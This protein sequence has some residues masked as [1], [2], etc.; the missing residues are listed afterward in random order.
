MF[1]MRRFLK[2]AFIWVGINIILT[3][4]LKAQQNLIIAN[5]ANI[6]DVKSS[7]TNP[8]ILPFQESQL[9]VGMKVFHVGFMEDSKLG[10]RNNYF[11][12]SSPYL[13]SD[14][15]VVGITGQ[16]FGVPIYKQSQFSFLI[17]RKLR[18]QFS[19]GMKYNALIH[20]Y[21]KTQ[22]DQIDSWD[23]VFSNRTM[24]V[25][26][27]FGLGLL[28][29][30]LSDLSVGFSWDHINKPDVSLNGDGIRQPFLFDFGIKYS[31]KLLST[32]VNMN[33]FQNSPTFVW[34]LESTF[35]DKGL[36]RVGYEMNAAKFEGQLHVGKG[37]WLNYSY[38]YPLYDLNDISSGSHQVSIIY[39]FDYERKDKVKIAEFPEYREKEEKK[40]R[41][42]VS[43]SN[44]QLKII[45]KKFKRSFDK[46]I[47]KAQLQNLTDLEIGELD[48]SENDVD[49][50]NPDY[51]SNN[52]PLNKKALNTKLSDDYKSCLKALSEQLESDKKKKIVV[53]HSDK[54]K[55]KKRASKYFSSSAA[56][57][58]KV[59]PLHT[60]SGPY[61]DLAKKGY[62]KEN[63]LLF[64]QKV[65]FEIIGT[66]Q[67]YDKDWKL[68]IK[69]NCGQVLKSFEGNGK[70]QSQIEWD[71]RDKD[72]EL[73]EAEDYYYTFYWTDSNNELQKTE[74]KTFKVIKV[75]RHLDVEITTKSRQEVDLNTTI[76]KI[77]LNN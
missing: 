48:C 65:S 19:I 57:Q 27:S 5:P 37:I 24:K 1:G 59:K 58:V 4:I 30:P 15:L 51:S 26:H 76:Y 53:F 43:I 23:P 31:Y 13:S 9:V 64:P 75:L 14:K 42:F 29:F 77:K 32:S 47:T 25:S 68:E 55:G 52:N 72:G 71:W 60:K 8:A 73:L 50:Y 35:P 67:K 46:E 17:G 22:F 10:F 7:F 3:P 62:E 21:D 45:N 2:L 61:I 69:D 66:K 70:I 39:D 33:L 40:D 18:N 54:D 36:V 49:F 74:P 34:M 11:S 38:D 6:F 12:L 63:I 16:Y 20:A 41:F 44:E 56:R 28:F